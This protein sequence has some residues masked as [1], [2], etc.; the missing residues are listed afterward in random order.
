MST[1]SIVSLVANAFIL[2]TAVSLAVIVYGCM[3][4]TGV[5]TTCGWT[6]LDF[7]I[8]KDVFQI[9]IWHVVKRLT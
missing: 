3:E 1:R 9:Q 8:K 2:L 7:K 4:K 6:R 5:I